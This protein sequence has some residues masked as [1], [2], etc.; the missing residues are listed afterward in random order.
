MTNDASEIYRKHHLSVDAHKRDA[1]EAARSA[2]Y[3]RAEAARLAELADAWD[4]RR[5]ECEDR[6]HRAGAA[7]QQ[8]R[9]SRMSALE[10]SRFIR[11]HPGGPA[12]GAE[13][14]KQLPK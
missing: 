4:A 2:E 14:F 11:S 3:L 13:A 12:A 5:D 10:I 1:A 6:A 9:R 7:E 8:L